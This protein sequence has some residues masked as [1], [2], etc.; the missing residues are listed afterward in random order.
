MAS[1]SSSSF[2]PL[3]LRHYVQ[4][5]ADHSAAAVLLVAATVST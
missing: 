4:L 3:P 2:M 1:A 5:R